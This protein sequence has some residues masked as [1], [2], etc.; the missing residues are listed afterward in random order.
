MDEVLTLLEDDNEQSDI[1]ADFPST[2]NSEEPDT[3]GEE[4]LLFPHNQQRSATYISIKPTAVPN[5]NP[6]RPG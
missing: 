4:D 5:D 1:S 2:A 6:A 3:Q